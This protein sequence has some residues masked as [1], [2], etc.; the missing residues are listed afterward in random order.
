MS[1]TPPLGRGV[2]PFGTLL[3]T[4]YG[5]PVAV[6]ADTGSD[7]DQLVFLLYQKKEGTQAQDRAI[8][9]FTLKGR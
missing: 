1:R 5:K 6:A 2:A 4:E 3:A 9:D 7:L 8:D